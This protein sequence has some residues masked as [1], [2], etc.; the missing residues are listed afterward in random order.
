MNDGADRYTPNAPY[1]YDCTGTGR[2]LVND[3]A[4][5]KLLPIQQQIYGE[6]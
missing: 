4:E 5:R 6:F 3:A 2:I 1:V